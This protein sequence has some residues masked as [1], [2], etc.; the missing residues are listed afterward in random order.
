MA[1]II[2]PLDSISSLFT[3]QGDIITFAAITDANYAAATLA[4]LT[5]G[6][7]LGDIFEGSTSWTGDDISFEELSNEQG[8]SVSTKTVVGS[9]KFEFTHMSVTATRIQKFMAGTTIAN[10]ATLPT[11]LAASPVPVITGFGTDVGVVTLPIALLNETK[12]RI[13][14]F[15]KAKIATSIIMNGT[16]I[17]LKSIVSAESINTANLKTMMLIN[18]TAVYASA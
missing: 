8:I 4:S 11:W 10:P 16:N 7:T 9:Y 3:G 5:T 1:T 13:L 17:M 18:G 15:P 6:L 12:D 2:N 14:V